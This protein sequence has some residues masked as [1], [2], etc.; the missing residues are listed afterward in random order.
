MF[1]L[2]LFLNFSSLL[3]FFAQYQKQSFKLQAVVLVL[4]VSLFLKYLVV[5]LS[6]WKTFLRCHSCVTDW[7]DVPLHKTHLAPF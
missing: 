6:S 3:I 5:S 1:P 7:C 4:M 2:K